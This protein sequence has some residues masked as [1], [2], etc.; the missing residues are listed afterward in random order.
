[1]PCYIITS[2][3]YWLGQLRRDW[4]PLTLEA[5]SLVHAF[6]SSHLDYCNSLLFDVQEKLLRTCEV[7][8]PDSRL[9]MRGNS[10][11]W[12]LCSVVGVSVK[13]WPTRL[14]RLW[15]RRYCSPVRPSFRLRLL[16]PNKSKWNIIRSTLLNWDV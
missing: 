3:Y 6:L 16:D 7:Q 8:E 1:M 11:A 15:M 10:M 9:M 2:C 13:Q 14:L 5:K 4:L 12:D